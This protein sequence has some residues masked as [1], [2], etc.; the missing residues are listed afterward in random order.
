MSG[1]F[2]K[3]AAKEAAPLTSRLISSNAQSPLASPL[4]PIALAVGANLVA[5]ACSAR[6]KTEERKY[7]NGYASA[8]SKEEGFSH[9]FGTN[10]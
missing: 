1:I 3:L 6:G 7:S 8:V 2:S 4:F 10:G 5:V 9:I